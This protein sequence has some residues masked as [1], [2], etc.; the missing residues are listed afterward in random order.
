MWYQR[1]GDALFA[2]NIRVV[3]PRSEINAGIM[4]TVRDEPQYFGYY[5][6]GITILADRIEIAP[7]GQLNRAVGRL[8]LTNAS[9]VNGAQTVSTLGAVLGTAAEPN[10]AE[11]FVMTRCIEVAPEDDQLARGITRYANTQNEVS[12]QDFAFLDE[13]QHRLAKELR[14]TGI[15]YLIRQSEK[16]SLKD[17]KMVIHVRE[18]AVALACAQ[19]DVGMAVVAKREVSR[20]FSQGGEYQR[21]FNP[22]TDPLVLARSVSTV[23][24]VDDAL[25]KLAAVSSGVELGVVVHGRL[26]IAHLVLHSVGVDKLR[27][28]AFD[29]VTALATKA[30]FVKGAVDAIVQAFPGNSYPGNVFKNRSRCAELLASAS[31]AS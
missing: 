21:L 31:L 4:E 3:I 2:E 18:A 25:D 9:I 22:S 27:D 17:P 11:T 24:F 14:V 20:L 5:N 1:H 23:R 28:P 30:S 10:L 12:S 29:F 19:K 8:R 13:Q 16:S 7:G 6:N 15:E 26:V